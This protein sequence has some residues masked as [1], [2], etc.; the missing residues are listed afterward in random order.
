MLRLASSRASLRLNGLGA[1]QGTALCPSFLKRASLSTRGQYFAPV[2]VKDGVAIIRIDGPGKMNT[3]DDNF[4]Q[5]IDALWTDKVANDASVKAAVIIS[6][7]PDNFIAGA[8]IKF[9]DSVEDFASLKDVCLKG[10]ATFQKIRKANKPLVAAIHGPA[11][12]GGLEVALYCDYRIVTSSP[13][14]VLGLPEVKLGL[15]PGF[16]GTQNLHPIVGLQAALDMTLTGA[17][18]GGR[19][20]RR[21]GGGGGG[22]KEEGVRFLS[23]SDRT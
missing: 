12:G 18:E 22:R 7:K 4:R 19:E 11:L 8:D 9:I 13:K 2:E 5:E 10:H 14:T 17:G 20:G 16:G 1:F 23:V 21:E 15:L 6:A 3:I